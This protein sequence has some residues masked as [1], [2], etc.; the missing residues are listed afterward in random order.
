[1]YLLPSEQ[2]EKIEQAIEQFDK[3]GELSIFEPCDCGSHIQH[4]NGGNYH[5][6]IYLKRDSGKVFVK[7]GTTCELVPL[8]H[9]AECN[10]FEEVIKQNADYL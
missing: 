4:N 5:E 2:K 6:E 10:D 7:Y 9:W 1:M 8:A 3:T